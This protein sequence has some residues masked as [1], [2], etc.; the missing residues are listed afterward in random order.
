[1][2]KKNT[3]EKK[4]RVKKKTWKFFDQNPLTH[5]AAHYLMTIERLVQSQGYARI[6][7]I[8]KELNITRGSCSISVKA[9]RKR[10]LVKED[11]NKFLQLSKEGNELVQVIKRNDELLETFFKDVLQVDEWQAEIDA[12]KIEHLVSMETSVQLAKFIDVLGADPTLSKKIRDL[13]Q[14]K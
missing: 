6:T 9:L 14:K 5:S 3:S 12:C 11:A 4:P 10:R 2:N 1:M 8:A 7:D 13:I